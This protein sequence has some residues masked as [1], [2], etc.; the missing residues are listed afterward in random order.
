MNGPTWNSGIGDHALASGAADDDCRLERPSR[1][2][3]GPRPGRPG[4]ASRRSSRGC[5]RPGRRSLP[6][7]PRRPGTA[8]ASRSEFSRSTWRVSAPIRIS[9]PSSADVR[10]LVEVVDVDQVLGGR[11]PELHHRDQAVA[12]GDDPRARADALQRC[13]R[14]IDARRTLV[15]TRRWGLHQLFPPGW[16]DGHPAAH[17]R[18][19]A[20]LVLDRRVGPDDRRA[21]HL[22]RASTAGR[23]GRAVAPPGS[24][25]RHCAAPARSGSRP[26]S[27]PHG[28]AVRA[29]AC[30]S[31]RPRRSAGP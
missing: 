25:A 13:D 12:A 24:R 20:R 30:P 7:R 1:P 8:G 19:F 10:E 14:A 3:S 18:V 9:L 22:R 27:V 5:G 4:R 29:S 26:R 17:A 16:S 15:V 11:E 31:C 21:R 2:R 6:R 28:R 23:P